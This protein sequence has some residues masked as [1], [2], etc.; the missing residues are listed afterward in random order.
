MKGLFLRD[1]AIVGIAAFSGPPQSGYVAIALQ[2]KLG[3]LCVNLCASASKGD[4]TPSAYQGLDFPLR[5]PG[6]GGVPIGAD[7]DPT[8]LLVFVN[9]SEC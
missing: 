8:M 3:P 7:G 1:A 4:P 9:L 6:F 5:I 2:A